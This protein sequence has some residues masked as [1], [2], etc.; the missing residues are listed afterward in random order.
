MERCLTFIT[1]FIC[2]ICVSGQTTQAACWDSTWYNDSG[3]LANRSTYEHQSVNVLDAICSNGP[4]IAAQCKDEKGESFQVT[5]NDSVSH[6]Y[7]TCSPVNGLMCQPYNNSQNATC[8]DFAIQY[9]CNCPTATTRG[10]STVST[11]GA[12]NQSVSSGAGNTAT[13][14]GV[15]LHSTKSVGTLKGSGGGIT[16]LKTGNGNGVPGYT[17]GG[18]GNTG[19]QTTGSGA[20][21][22]ASGQ[23]NGHCRNDGQHYGAS[24]LVL[25][26]CTITLKVLF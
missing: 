18:S 25:L 26:L 5:K 14:Q 1:G 6:F 24:H 11:Q 15:V 13:T 19:L 3:I 21:P 12:K 16:T 7:A 4:V 9:G 22:S 10:V 20:G 17:N 2:V 8:P 23:Q